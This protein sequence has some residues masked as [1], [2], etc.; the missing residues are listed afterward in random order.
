MNPSPSRR[1]LLI[2]SLGLAGSWGAMGS[3]R[4]AGDPAAT[5]Q[6]AGGLAVL[7]RHARTEPGVGDPPGYDL[8]V[9]SSQRQLSAEGRAQSQRIGAWFAERRLLPTAVRSSRWCR[10][11]DTGALAFRSPAVQLWEPLNST[12][13]ER[14]GEAPRQTA[15]ARRALAALR[16]RPGFEVWVTHMVNIQAI[17]GVTVAMGE[18]LI[19]RAPAEAGGAVQ[20]LAQWR[21]GG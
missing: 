7:I 15:E 8:A 13:A 9:C 14:A 1:R 19:V 11:V 18:A 5:L 10:C 12:F 17:A 4:A 20:V 6:G 3:V 21:P 2:T 16:G